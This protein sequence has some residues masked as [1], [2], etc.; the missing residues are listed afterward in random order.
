MNFQND[1]E[2]KLFQALIAAGIII[3]VL[4]SYAFF[5]TSQYKKVAPINSEEYITKDA[6]EQYLLSAGVKIEGQPRF[7]FSDITN[8]TNNRE[9]NISV[10]F[11][12]NSE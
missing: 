4:G 10:Q 11:E 6:C 8:I 7:N 5:L 1:R 12:S 2:K 9:M 3:L